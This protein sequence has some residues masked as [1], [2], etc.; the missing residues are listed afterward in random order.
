M[1]D[2][3]LRQRLLRDIPLDREDETLEFKRLLWARKAPAA[4]RT[5]SSTLALMLAC[6]TFVAGAMFDAGG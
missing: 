6:R 1:D 2:F 5:R 4:E 3:G